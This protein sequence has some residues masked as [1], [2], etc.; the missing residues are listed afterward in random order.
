MAIPPS[1][2]DVRMNGPQPQMLCQSRKPAPVIRKFDFPHPCSYLVTSTH[3]DDAQLRVYADCAFV[4]QIVS[5]LRSLSSSQTIPLP[6][7]RDAS[8]LPSTI[9]N[10]SCSRASAQSTYSSQ[11][12]VGVAERSLS[13]TSCIK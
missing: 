7:C 6:G 13:R 2:T 11:W 10:G 1:T 12:S 9:R 8:T 5:S 4:D 3:P